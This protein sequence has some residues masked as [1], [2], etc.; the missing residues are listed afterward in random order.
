MS[1]LDFFHHEDLRNI[2]DEITFNKSVELQHI[3]Y[4]IIDGENVPKNKINRTYRCCNTKQ[5]IIDAVVPGNFCELDVLGG[6]FSVQWFYYLSQRGDHALI[7]ITPVLN[8][9]FNEIIDYKFNCHLIASKPIEGT[10]AM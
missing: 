2:F 10:Y 8:N 5:S 1:V 3:E 6:G 4:I 9:N 7:Y